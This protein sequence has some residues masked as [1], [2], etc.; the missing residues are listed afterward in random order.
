MRSMLAL[1][2]LALLFQPAVI[3]EDAAVDVLRAKQAREREEASRI[4]PTFVQVYVVEDLVQFFKGSPKRGV[5]KVAELVSGQVPALRGG[6]VSGFPTNLSVV[7]N[8]SEEGHQALEKY[9]TQLRSARKLIKDAGLE[10][11]ENN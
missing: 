5:E 3:A 8:S 9:L 2:L 11:V 7:V 6:T 4:P 10:V 1:A